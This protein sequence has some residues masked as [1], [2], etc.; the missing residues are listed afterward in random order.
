MFI[1]D[2]ENKLPAVEFDILL[3]LICLLHSITLGGN[4]A[5]GFIIVFLIDQR[6]RCSPAGQRGGKRYNHASFVMVL[7]NQID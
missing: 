4:Y 3:A 2:N 5:I 1:D 6:R 7:D